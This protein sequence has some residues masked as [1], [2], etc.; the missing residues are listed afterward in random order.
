MNP[1]NLLKIFHFFIDKGAQKFL[2]ALKISFQGGPYGA[3]FSIQKAIT[4]FE[5]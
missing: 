2:R 4:V 1:I 5:F 3:H